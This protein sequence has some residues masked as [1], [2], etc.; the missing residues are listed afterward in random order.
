MV[1]GFVLLATDVSL[2]AEP[3]QVDSAP[4]QVDSA[5][6]QTDPVQRPRG[7][8][9]TRGRDIPK[10]EVPL[11][12]EL[13][14][15]SRSPR[16]HSQNFDSAPPDEGSQEDKA[17]PAFAH[18]VQRPA[19]YDPAEHPRVE[20]IQKEMDDMQNRDDMQDKD[21]LQAVHHVHRPARYNPREHP[22]QNPE[23]EAKGGSIR[24][25]VSLVKKPARDPHRP[26]TAG[27][28]LQ[29][30]PHVHNQQAEA[31]VNVRLGTPPPAAQPTASVKAPAY[32]ATERVVLAK[33]SEV[34]VTAAK[35]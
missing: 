3:L 30:N 34:T 29:M 7:G 23:Y 9:V 10:W 35:R 15:M 31:D 20:A 16:K 6:V 14:K 22:R 33:T 17:E 19:R 4:L 26:R 21:P 25:Q 8:R 1:L 11:Q 24:E 28:L 5:P 27:E 18:N 13:D 2:A 32:P 12:K